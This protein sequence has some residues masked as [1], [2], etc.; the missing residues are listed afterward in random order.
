MNNKKVFLVVFIATILALLI[1]LQFLPK[2]NNSNLD[3]TK[4]SVS[5][6]NVA[7]EKQHE[8]KETPPVEEISQNEQ[9]QLSESKVV[10]TET[11]NTIK[12]NVPVFEKLQVKESMKVERAE[13][14]FEDPGIIN[15][16]GTIVVTRAFRVKSPDKYCFEGFGIQK[17]PTK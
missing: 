15:D 4:E 3:T 1:A 16:N 9:A 11:N 7:E 10:K 17:A 6:E 13:I 14:S 12:E 2:R 5:I 8:K